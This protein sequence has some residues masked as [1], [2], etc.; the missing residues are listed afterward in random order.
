MNEWKDN[1]G[2]FFKEAEKKETQEKKS[3]AEMFIS[4][5]VAPA[6]KDLAA[7]LEKHGRD[8]TVRI[9][10]TSAAIMINK[11]G[12]EELSYRMQVRMFPTGVLP[13]AEIRFR[14]RGGLKLITTENM[15]RSGNKPYKI[16]DIKKKEVIEHFVSNYTSRTQ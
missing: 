9:S 2:S 11:D 12:E 8:V 4:K 3:E 10:D 13:C 15:I 14:Q 1:L 16:M 7:E 5:V 6:F